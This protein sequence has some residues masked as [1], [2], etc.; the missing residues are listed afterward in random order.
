MSMGLR[1]TDIRDNIV[2]S[3]KLTLTDAERRVVMKMREIA[4][5]PRLG[6]IVVQCL[7]TQWKVHQT[8]MCE[9]VK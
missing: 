5:Q 4:L 2:S 3:E 1:S 7:G 6:M 9:H 8:T